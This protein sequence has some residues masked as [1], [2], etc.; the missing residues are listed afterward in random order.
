LILIYVDL[1]VGGVLDR[2]KY[3]NWMN[4]S[5]GIIDPTWVKALVIDDGRTPV[6][7]LTLDMIG[8]SGRHVAP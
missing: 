6:A 8:A 5:Q 7:F 1:G 4:P 3:C 2:E